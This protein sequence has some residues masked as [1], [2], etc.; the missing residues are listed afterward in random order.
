MLVMDEMLYIDTSRPENAYK[1]Q[2]LRKELRDRSTQKLMGIDSLLGLDQNQLE[3]VATIIFSGGDGSL[4]L[5][6]SIL[7]LADRSDIPILLAGGGTVETLK[8]QL[9]RLI[10]LSIE[11]PSALDAFSDLNLAARSYKPLELVS[12]TTEGESKQLAAYLA[13]FGEMELAATARIDR[14]LELRKK[15]GDLLANRILTPG[16]LYALGGLSTVQ[17]VAGS[18]RS[19]L[20]VERV[21]A[22]GQIVKEEI[23]GSPIAAAISVPQLGTFKFEQTIPPDLVWLLM[24]EGNQ[25]TMLLKY[26]ISLLIGA[27][28]SH[29]PE[30]L[31][32]WGLLGREEVE[33][34]TL[35][36]DISA[37]YAHQTNVNTDGELD[38]IGQAVL[39]QRSSEEFTFAIPRNVAGEK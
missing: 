17:S 19:P 20:V 2:A 31:V 18:H 33:S 26:I 15:V 32:D 16:L 28:F 14:L 36:P 27:T 23:A 9:L 11:M 12:K 5:L 34:V 13:G 37:R 38:R 29:G 35:L 24:M 8:N 7:C 39:I 30:M 25:Q 1:N 21:L 10:E 4:G 6:L 22:D 3:K